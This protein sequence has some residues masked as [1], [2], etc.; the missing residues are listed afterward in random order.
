[1]EKFQQQKQ[2]V[3]EGSRGNFARDF[4][5]P[6]EETFFSY[7]PR[8]TTPSMGNQ[9]R[10]QTETRSFLRHQ[11]ALSPSHLSPQQMGPAETKGFHWVE[12]S[13][14]TP[15]LLKS[16]HGCAQEH[17]VRNLGVRSAVGW[18]K[19]PEGQD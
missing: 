6:S 11:T 12:K 2:T 18:G 4:F 5:A 1:M 9:S 14:I 17:N 10:K 7:V 15:L 3:L 13:T 8:T 16:K 19:Y